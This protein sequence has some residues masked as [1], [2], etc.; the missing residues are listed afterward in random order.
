MLHYIFFKIHTCE[1]NTEVFPKHSVIT[2]FSI[3]I[4]LLFVV[5][6]IQTLKEIPLMYMLYFVHFLVQRKYVNSVLTF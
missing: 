2:K 4:H 3:V 1:T 6:V 5:Y